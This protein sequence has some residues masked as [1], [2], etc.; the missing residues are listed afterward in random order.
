MR[1]L[2]EEPH[3]RQKISPHGLISVQSMCLLLRVVRTLF[4]FSNRLGQQT[5][6]HNIQ[7][8]R[9]VE[10]MK[11]KHGLTMRFFLKIDVMFQAQRKM[12][13]TLSDSIRISS[14]IRRQRSAGIL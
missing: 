14:T 12:C 11:A 10:R 8:S 13:N 9:I 1:A 5:P 2:N 3:H 4:L 6:T 7:I